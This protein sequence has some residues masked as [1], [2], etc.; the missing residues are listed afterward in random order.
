VIGTASQQVATSF[1]GDS[2]PMPAVHAFTDDAL[3]DDDAVAIAQNVR[4]GDISAHEAVEAAINRANAVNPQLAA[5]AIE[6]FE[7]ARNT[8]SGNGSAAF[9]GVPTFV[10]DMTDVAGLPTRFGCAT[11]KDRA[12]A[13]KTH[14]IA[15]QL[16]D[17]GMVSIGKST[18]PEFG[19]TPS[20]EF[21]DDPPTRNPWNPDH[22][23]G[24][25]S[26]GAASLVAAG[27]VPIANA[28]D[29]GGSIRIPAAACGLVGLKPTRGRISPAQSAEPF[30]GLV[31]D[32]VVTRSV[33][34]TALF[35]A[36]NEKLYRSQKLPEIGMVDRPLE[37]SL[38][39]G[40][41][42]K[43]PNGAEL[44]DVTRRELDSCV[45]LLEALGH[46][47]EPFDLKIEDQFTEDFISFWSAL[48]FLVAVTSRWTLGSEFDRS[49]LADVTQGLAKHGK[50][51][52]FR[53]PGA[54]RRLRN[55]HQQY[56][57]QFTSMDVM[58]CP[59]VGHATPEIG[60]LGMDLPFDV[61]F[62]RI[63]QWACFTP[64]ANAT[65]GPA[66]SLPV[67]FD[68][69]SNLPV[70]MMFSADVGQDRLLL[71]LGL[72]LEAAAPWRAIQQ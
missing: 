6:D 20:T 16:L 57:E 18:M 34:D 41:V 51:R 43:S 12:P 55:S 65:G 14:T 47:V 58:L 25:S 60:H 49:K 19:F 70:G 54:I 63:E 7:R 23:A 69:P 61:L 17:M 44:D 59:V 62:P 26:G 53:L 2:M 24:G 40:V 71:E 3:S 8:K 36:E 21:P 27:V 28:A 30:V 56:S 4:A 46:K 1:S 37:R 10:K 29:G 52:L 13:K 15:Q 32:G 64:Y 66:I 11:L 48:A 33:R 67:G 5:I 68:P 35:Y 72:Q 39:I 22:S 50:S 38:Q 31:T 9:A 42:T 45:R